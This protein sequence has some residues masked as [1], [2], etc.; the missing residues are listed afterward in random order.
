MGFPDFNM[1][2]CHHYPLSF[3]CSVAKATFAVY[4]FTL[5]GITSA[6]RAVIDHVAKHPCIYGISGAFIVGGILFLLVPTFVGFGPLG[7]I[8]GQSLPTHPKNSW[9]THAKE[10]GLQDGRAKSAM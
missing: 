7:P 1:D 2:P 6:Y 8:A 3:V 10:A 5:E 4:T 9:L